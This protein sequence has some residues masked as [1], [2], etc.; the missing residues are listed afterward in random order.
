MQNSVRKK[1]MTMLTRAQAQPPFLKFFGRYRIPV[2][3][4]PLSR[5]K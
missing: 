3:M 2:Q 4:K 1:L 5:L